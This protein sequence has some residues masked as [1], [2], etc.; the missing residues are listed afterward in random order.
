MSEIRIL[1][2][3]G[4]GAVTGARILVAAA[5]EEGKYAQSIPSFGQER[6]GAPVFTYARISNAP[7]LSHSY[8]YAP[9]TVVLFDEFLVELGIDP[10]EGIV[11]GSTLVVNT[12]AVYGDDRE[13]WPEAYRGFAR[14]GALDAWKTTKEV[15]GDVPPNAAMLGA[16]AK[17]TGLIGVDALLSGIEYS[18]P[19][20]LAEKNKECAKLAYARTVLCG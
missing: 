11:P 5:M 19:A 6:K 9:D 3:G 15:L 14:I 12:P 8:V 20:R 17:A 13:A 7:I 16:I 2:R 4:Q 18:L 10:Q 1:S